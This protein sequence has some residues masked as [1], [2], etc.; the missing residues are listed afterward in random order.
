MDLVQ[1]MVVLGATTGATSGSAGSVGSAPQE[2]R[3]T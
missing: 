1:Y 2:M 3:V